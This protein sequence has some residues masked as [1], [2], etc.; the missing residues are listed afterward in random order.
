VRN[1]HREAE[2]VGQH[3]TNILTLDTPS[4]R[5]CQSYRSAGI[6]RRISSDLAFRSF[7]GGPWVRRLLLFT[8]LILACLGPVVPDSRLQALQGIAVNREYAI[9]AAFLYHFLNYINWPEDSLKDPTQPFIIGVYHSDPFGVVLDKIA[10]TK[11]VEGRAIEI[12]RLQTT[13]QILECHIL[14]VPRTVSRDVQTSVLKSLANSHVLAVGE[15]DDFIEQ[16]GSAQFFEEGNK[17]RFAFNTDAVNRS[18]LKISSKLLSIAKVV[19]N[20]TK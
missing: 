14:F 8:L 10:E 4:E 9:K 17:I 7:L 15:T 16:G 18:E 5:D 1:T 12:R 13:D 6:C 20:T 2:K 19:S 11:Q 3:Y